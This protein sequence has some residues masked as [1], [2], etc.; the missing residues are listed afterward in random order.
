LSTV[1]SRKSEAGD[2]TS[3]NPTE[4]QI[5]SDRVLGIPRLNSKLGYNELRLRDQ[6]EHI[7]MVPGDSFSGL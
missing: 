6:K 2:R 7:D 3:Y 1:V 5:R 4:W